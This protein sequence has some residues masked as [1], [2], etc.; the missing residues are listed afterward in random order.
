MCKK[1]LQANEILKYTWIVSYAESND[2][3]CI[4]VA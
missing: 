2:C 4:T 3:I 1:A